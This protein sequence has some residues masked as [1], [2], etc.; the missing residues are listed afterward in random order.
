MDVTPLFQRT[1][2]DHIECLDRLNCPD[3]FSD[4]SPYMFSWTSE[5][6]EVFGR[7]CALVALSCYGDYDDELHETLNIMRRM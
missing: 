1:L 4:E 2:R 6:M 3:M 5:Y 7:G